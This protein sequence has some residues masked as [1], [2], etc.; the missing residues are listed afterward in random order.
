MQYGVS[1]SRS[2]FMMS[3][4]GGIPC[5]LLRRKAL[6]RYQML[7]RHMFYCKHVERQLCSVWISNKAAKQHALHSA[8]WCVLCPHG[9]VVLGA[10]LCSAG[11][12]LTTNQVHWPCP[13]AACTDLWACHHLC[14]GGSPQRTVSR[15]LGWDPC[16][17]ALICL[18]PRHCA[19]WSAAPG[20][21]VPVS[22]PQELHH[23]CAQNGY[24][25]TTCT[26][27]GWVGG[28]QESLVQVPAPQRLS[29]VSVHPGLPAPSRCDSGC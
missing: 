4:V 1:A 15:L 10:H 13:P 11:L 8:K 3:G 28:E 27:C 22:E 17:S 12:L 21:A 23:G 19:H 26:R 6:T 20:V 7:F 24:S 18:S 29:D 25:P 2:L 5:P 16:G 14:V 9:E